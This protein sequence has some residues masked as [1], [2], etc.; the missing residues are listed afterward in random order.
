MLGVE[1]LKGGWGEIRID[2]E[3]GVASVKCVRH[4]RFL[5]KESRTMMV[6]LVSSMSF[7]A[8]NGLV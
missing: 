7:A 3:G 5:H 4:H 6:F 1:W 2:A 8:R